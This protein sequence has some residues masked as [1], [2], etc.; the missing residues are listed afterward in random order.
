MPDSKSVPININQLREFGAKAAKL[1][2]AYQ[3]VITDL[4]NKNLSELTVNLTPAPGESEP[5]SG[6]YRPKE[7]D[8]VR[9]L[10]KKEA[11]RTLA[12]L[13]E[14]VFTPQQ[15][16]KVMIKAGVL[17]GGRNSSFE[18]N[19]LLNEMPDMR[20]DKRNRW[21]MLAAEDSDGITVKLEPARLRASDLSLEA[22]RRMQEW[23]AARKNE[24]AK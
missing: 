5:I 16:R 24:A 21:I 23:V 19:G 10:S 2:K 8:S 12:S 22:Q 7:V 9:G 13:N 20:H 1:A 18:L 14:N 4:E 17:K 11:I 3:L 6:L 15:H